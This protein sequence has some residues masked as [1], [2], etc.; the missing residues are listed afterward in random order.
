MISEHHNNCAKHIAKRSSCSTRQKERFISVSL[1]FCSLYLTCRKCQWHCEDLT[2]CRPMC[3][4]VHHELGKFTLNTHGWSLQSS[5]A[6]AS[7]TCGCFFKYVLGHCWYTVHHYNQSNMLYCSSAVSLDH[8]IKPSALWTS[9]TSS[10]S[11]KLPGGWYAAVSPS[12]V[13][14]DSTES[15]GT[16]AC[17]P[18]PQS[19]PPDELHTHTQY[20]FRSNTMKTV[21]HKSAG[22]ILLKILKG[23]LWWWLFQKM[24]G[25]CVLWCTW[26][27]HAALWWGRQNAGQL[28][29]KITTA[30]YSTLFCMHDVLGNVWAMM[31]LQPPHSH[32]SCRKAW[33]IT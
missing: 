1:S 28:M 22:K 32:T 25:M 3:V 14:T 17:S 21:I 20:L 5:N 15:P 31:H 33:R 26:P 12:V 13:H 6:L 23:L 24:C 10:C 29:S 30:Y 8:A 9:P 4:W 16:P 19:H 27:P 7:N 11:Y 18:S 2:N